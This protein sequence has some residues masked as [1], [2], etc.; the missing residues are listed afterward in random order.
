MSN[1][2]ISR[3]GFLSSSALLGAG[4]VIGGVIRSGSGSSLAADG[5]PDATATRQAELDELHAL[6]T[7]VA[8]PPVCTPMP[9]ETPEPTATQIPAVPAGT[10]LKY[11]DI[12][13]ITVIGIS[14]TPG[15]AVVPA[16][17]FLKV[18]MTISHTASDSKLSPVFDFELV[19]A[20]GQHYVANPTTNQDVLGSSVGLPVGVG[21]QE[22]R[23]VVYDVPVDV[24]TMFLLET[25]KDPLFRVALEMQQRG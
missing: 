1:T 7:Q 6:Q 4:M 16:G 24:G 22:S 25:D 21:V 3:R 17:Q 5:T 13:T 8:N 20:S 2:V 14:P 9:T 10:S 12:W 23:S 15:G 19:D 11:L 18:D